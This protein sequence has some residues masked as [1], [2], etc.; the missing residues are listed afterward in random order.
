MSSYAKCGKNG[1]HG[2]FNFN[3]KSVAFVSQ[4]TVLKT[5][6]VLEGRWRPTNILEQQILV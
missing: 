4:T 2:L 1:K 5:L 6:T 3:G